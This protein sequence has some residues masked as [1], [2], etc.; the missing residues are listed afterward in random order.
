VAEIPELICPVCNGLEPLPL[1]RCPCGG[2]LHD[3][4]RVEDAL[5]P[6]SQA[7]EQQVFELK[8]TARFGKGVC[9]HRLICD[10][11][12]G[13]RITVVHCLPP[14]QPEFKSKKKADGLP[15]A[16]HQARVASQPFSVW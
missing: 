2:K 6:Y 4:G 7:E 12:H 10:L 8:E 15:S 14:G 3:E 11:C 5:G 1:E 16:E 9:L 13:S